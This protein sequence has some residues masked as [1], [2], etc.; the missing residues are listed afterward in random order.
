M[1]VQ[2][3]RYVNVDY[4]FFDIV[5]Y[6]LRT[7][8][9][10]CIIVTTLNDIILKSL[11]ATADGDAAATIRL[12]SG[13]GVCVAFT[14]SNLPYDAPIQFALR[15]LEH[16]A[17]YSQ[18]DRDAVERIEVRVGINRSIDAK[19]KD[20]NG[21]QN[22]AGR[23]INIAQRVM[24]LGSAS[25]ILLS[26]TSADVLLAHDAYRR[27]LKRYEAVVKHGENLE[28]YQFV[29]PALPYLGSAEPE[30]LREDIIDRRLEAALHSI[31]QAEPRGLVAYVTRTLGEHLV[32]PYRKDLSYRLVVRKME[33]NV[34]TITRETSYVTF[35][36]GGNAQK[37][38]VWAADPDEYVRVTSC[39]MYY[40]TE[41]SGLVWNDAIELDV[42]GAETFPVPGDQKL[43][44][45]AALDI[46]SSHDRILIGIE[47]EYEIELGKMQQW[48]MVVPTHGL[49]FECD[50]SAVQGPD[51][52]LEFELMTFILGARRVPFSQT[53]AVLRFHHPGWIVPDS[54]F[55]WRLARVK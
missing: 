18:P 23:G 53:G 41:Q 35:A 36:R 28:V 13:D 19:I 48:M 50:A 38:V 26:S 33:G 12:P 49:F 25:T 51:S 17:A 46:S 47:A 7:V 44:L 31:I 54:G 1:G 11:P 22:L 45:T 16:L 30:D 9:A 24:N 15:V 8:E 3:L 10:Q 40:K 34:L 4:V 32:G 20:I 37:E 29:D 52:P 55:A 39:R 6:S 14:D 43:E 27:R 5:A 21:K 42:R 2:K